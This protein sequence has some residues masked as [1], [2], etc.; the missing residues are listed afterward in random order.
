M[1]HLN[2]TF[3]LFVLMSMVGIQASA[4]DISVANSDGV[5]IYYTWRNSK[6]ELSVSYGGFSTKYS[7]HV[8][9]PEF[10]TYS[11]TTY[12]VTSI[13]YE[14][15]RGCSELTSVTIPNSVTSIGDYAFYDCS[16]LTSVTIPNSV[17]SIGEYAF[18]YC[19]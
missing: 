2:I 5:T 16:G 19:I 15:F 13:G 11:G 4:Y 17:T 9:I 6:T 14:A 12:P 1:K 3:L 8:T 10:V 7:G 18:A